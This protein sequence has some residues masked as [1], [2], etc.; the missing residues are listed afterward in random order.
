[1]SPALLPANPVAP[2]DDMMNRMLPILLGLCLAASNCLGRQDVL[3]KAN[4]LELTGQFKAA[5]SELSQAITNTPPTAPERK[6]LEFERGAACRVEEIRERFY[7]PGVRGMGA[8]GPIRQPGNRRAQAFH[9][10]ERQQ[11]FLQIPGALP[12]STSAARDR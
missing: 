10:L 8:G 4:R 7:G 2:S 3:E 1:M 11:P 6:T 9:G 5:A 12:T